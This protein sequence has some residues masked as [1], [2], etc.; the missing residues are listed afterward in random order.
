MACGFNFLSS[1]NSNTAIIEKTV[2]IEI[3]IACSESITMAIRY[4]GVFCVV[5]QQDVCFSGVAQLELQPTPDDPLQTTRTTTIMID[6][7]H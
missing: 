4:E 7:C 6:T 3:K 1:G 2:I 5:A